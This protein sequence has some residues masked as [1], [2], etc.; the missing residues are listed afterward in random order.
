MEIRCV[1]EAELSPKAIISI[2]SDKYLLKLSVCMMSICRGVAGQQS[3]CQD[4]KFVGQAH[5]AYQVACMNS[6]RILH[7]TH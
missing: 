5:S 3:G 1:E 6:P 4:R 7:S 2:V